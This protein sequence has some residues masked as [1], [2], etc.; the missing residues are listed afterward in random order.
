MSEGSTL[1]IVFAL[2]GGLLAAIAVYIFMR[3]R[4]FVSNAQE[5]KGTVIQLVYR[6]GGSNS[7]GGYAPVYQFKTKEGKSIVVADTLSSNPPAF[8]EGQVIDVLYDPANPEKARIKR[9]MSL[10]F[11]PVLLGGMGVLFGGAGIAV[12]VAAGG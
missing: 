8:K 10:Y 6:G 7:G 12:L 3:T 4:S 9:F 5:V 11:A 1:G 2:L